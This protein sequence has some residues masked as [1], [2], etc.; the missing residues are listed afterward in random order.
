MEQTKSRFFAFQGL[1]ILLI[2]AACSNEQQI[3]TPV[4]Q[5]EEPQEAPTPTG[6]SNVDQ[7]LW[8][9]YTDFETEA[10]SRGLQIDLD[11]LGITGTFEDLEGE[12]VAGQCT[13]TRFSPNEVRIDTEFWQRASNNLREMIIFHELGHCVLLR[14]HEEG[15]LSNGACLSIMR[16][17]NGS[18]ID[19]YRGTTR[20]F[21][22]DEL[23]EN[24]QLN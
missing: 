13:F 21:Y 16:S 23:F 8:S 10:A 9:F 24:H 18:C 15:S 12:H 14:D 17:G 4:A 22:L 6:F 5:E 3:L 7:A 11:A 19:N 1:I 2:F 20:S